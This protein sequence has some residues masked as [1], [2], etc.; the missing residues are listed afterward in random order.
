MEFLNRNVCAYGIN[1]AQIKNGLC[2]ALHLGVFSNQK[3]FI[4]AELGW[5]NAGCVFKKFKSRKAKNFFGF[6]RKSLVS[7]KVLVENY[8][9][10]GSKIGSCLRNF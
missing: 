7:Q 3:M 2:H 4:Y 10:F 9:E 8:R 1:K 6:F 5:R